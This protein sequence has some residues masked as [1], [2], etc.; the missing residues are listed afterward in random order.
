M[1]RLLLP[2]LLALGALCLLAGNAGAQ[3]PER[4]MYCCMYDTPTPMQ[5]KGAYPV[6]TGV[7][8][9]GD[10]AQTWKALGWRTNR[11]NDIVALPGAPDALFLA[12]DY[13]LLGSSDRGATWK[14]LTD[15]RIPSVLAVQAI[16]KLLVLAT[17]AGVFTSSDR[18]AT[19]IARNKGLKPLNG[20]YVSGLLLQPGVWFAATAN[21]VYRSGDAGA[22]WKPAGLQGKAV[23]NILPAPDNGIAAFGSRDGIWTSS[24]GGRHWNALSASLPTKQVQALVFHPKE[25]GVL[26]AGTRDHGLFRSSDGGRTWANSGAGIQTMNVTAI[27]FDPD[28]ASVVWAGTENGLYISRNGGAVWQIS[29]LRLGHISNIRIW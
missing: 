26:F 17:P 16:D 15:E 20:T 29:T 7:A 25:T 6:Y 8:F 3:Q 22:S 2:S 27:A 14:L 4:R 13:G 11:S 28:D 10:R 5:A 9:S 21:G 12:N 23:D 24:D 18:G 19:F 1:K